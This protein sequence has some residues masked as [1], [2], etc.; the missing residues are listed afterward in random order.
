M[1]VYPTKKVA[2]VLGD[3]YFYEGNL[4][5]SVRYFREMMK[6][7]FDL[8][9]YNSIYRANYDRRWDLPSIFVSPLMN[10]GSTFV[11]HALARG[12]GL[13]MYECSD[14]NPWPH[15]EVEE[16]KLRQCVGDRGVTVNHYFPTDR[17]LQLLERYYPKAV[18]H[19]RDPR[20][21]LLSYVHYCEEVDVRDELLEKRVLT[22]DYYVLPLARKIDWQIENHF[23]SMI[24]W[25]E[26]WT[27]VADRK[28]ISTQLLFTTFETM[29]DD[30]HGF[31]DRILVF[32]GIPAARF[33]QPPGSQVLGL[34]LR[35]ALK[36]EWRSQLTEQQCG[37]V[38]AMLPDSYCE[39]FGWIR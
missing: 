19:V 34:P 16:D 23:D 22:D 27:E 6:G 21:T 36:D 39:R 3:C 30:L 15:R 24:R 5:S 25:I 12:L 2:Q 1:A 11:E 38:N 9:A 29:K 18:L 8:T 28:K 37:R 26:E 33:V 20:Q 7:G 13:P 17:I 35:K 32:Y 31:F 10:S 4:E 14:G